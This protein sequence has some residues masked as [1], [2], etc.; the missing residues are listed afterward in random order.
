MNAVILKCFQV[1]LEGSIVMLFVM[2]FRFLLRKAPKKYICFLWMVALLRLCIPNLPQGPIPAFWKN[3][4][5]TKES[6]EMNA[7]QEWQDSGAELL[8]ADRESLEKNSLKTDSWQ[9]IQ[10][11]GEQIVTDVTLQDPAQYW[12]N[13]KEFIQDKT[14]E[15]ADYEDQLVGEVDSFDQAESITQTG[16]VIPEQ[17]S[18]ENPIS[19]GIWT[20][21]NRI[22]FLGILWLLGAVISY[23]LIAVRY[24]KI[25]RRLRE[26]IPMEAFEGHP[27][28]AAFL[29]GLP[30]VF[31]IFHPCIYFPADY[32]EGNG[33][34]K[35]YMLLHEAMHLERGDHVLKLFSM[36]VLGLYWWNPLVWLGVRLL[37]EDLEMACDEGVLAKLTD[38]C[39]ITYA[40]V[41]LN[42]ATKKSGIVLS[43]AFAESS[44]EQRIKNILRYKK[45]PIILSLV[46]ILLVGIVVVTVMTRPRDL[47]NENRNDTEQTTDDLAGNSNGQGAGNAGSDEFADHPVEEKDIQEAEKNPIDSRWIADCEEYWKKK[48]VSEGLVQSAKDDLFFYISDDCEDTDDKGS[49]YNI[50]LLAAAVNEIGEVSFFMSQGDVL[51]KEDGKKEITGP[52]HS[53]ITEL[54]DRESLLQ[55]IRI[56]YHIYDFDLDEKLLITEVIRR[57]KEKNPEAYALLKQ[58]EKAVESL[59]PLTGGKGTFTQCFWEDGELEYVFSDGE[60]AYLQMA[61]YNDIWYPCYIKDFYWERNPEAKSRDLEFLEQ[62]KQGNIYLQEVTADT[63]RGV[64]ESAE[65]GTVKS[66]WYD[67][68]ENRFIILNQAEGYDAVLYAMYGGNGL[69]LRVGNQVCPI[70]MS[71]VSPQMHLPVLLAG[72]YDSDGRTEYAIRTHFK[73][74]TGVS[75]DQLYI[76][77]LDN[78]GYQIHPFEEYDKQRML[79][80]IDYDYEEASHLL[81]VHQDNGRDVYMSLG[82]FL[83]DTGEDGK[84]AEFEQL[85]FGDIESF[86]LM[87]G[88]WY[89]AAEGGIRT[90]NRPSPQ[91]ECSMQMICPVIYRE[92]EGFELGSMQ[93]EPMYFAEQMQ[94]AEYPAWQKVVKIWQSDLTHDGKKEDIVLSITCQEENRELD[95]QQLLAMGETC[96]VRVYSQDIYDPHD[97][98]YD[99]EKYPETDGYYVGAALWESQDLAQ[100]HT[101]NGSVFLVKK[102]GK[103]YLL[104]NQAGFWQGV[105]EAGFRVIQITENC[106]FPYIVDEAEIMVDFNSDRKEDIEDAMD[107]EAMAAYTEKL[108]EWIGNGQLLIQ[109]D[110]EGECRIALDG[111]LKYDAWEIWKKAEA[112]VDEEVSIVTGAP[113]KTALKD[114]FSLQKALDSM[115]ARRM[116]WAETRNNIP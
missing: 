42:Y 74:G 21:E 73:T 104:T 47:G 82:K 83:Q 41:L 61:Q 31:G 56:P 101:G 109:T 36:L 1:A 68:L 71:W 23:I 26:A 106:N 72:D 29:S 10:P 12:M 96:K 6:V 55:M 115:K 40:T 89:Y 14:E 85:V 64:K 59:L 69:V 91:Y 112:L 116:Y 84:S 27:V 37:H 88:R 93:F 2:L 100:A 54:S 92:A 45:T 30:A 9:E 65:S 87:D 86:F 43:A 103:D 16:S 8:T 11:Q 46:M 50:S 20:R 22:R 44:T 34:G 98:G 17:D 25:S 7:P 49:D 75:G 97:G 32:M 39:R 62:Y 94:S 53:E 4:E 95:D 3:V 38:E 78:D 24:H 33:T 15:G 58:P 67:K 110:V 48:L 19:V 114:M 5:N 51:T 77:E 60:K 63:L 113:E 81:V 111:K 102:D 99:V 28:K 70:Y 108:Q 13:H 57:R 76:V 80:R 79:D 35:E 18:T 90:D 52:V 105:F 66:E 107:V